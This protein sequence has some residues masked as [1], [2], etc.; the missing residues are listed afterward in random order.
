[1][2]KRSA[3]GRGLE[4]LIPSKPKGI[5]ELIEVPLEKVRPNP[6]QARKVFTEEKIAELAASIAEHGLVQP[7]VVRR[8]DDGYE[9]VSGERRWRAYRSLGRE[10]IPAIVREMGDLEATAALLIENIQREDLSPLEEALAFRRLIE[11]FR[12][13][14]EDL[15]RRVGKSRAAIANTLR[16]LSLPADVQ[17]M[18]AG[19]KL[20]AGH[21]RA[22]AG[23]KDAARQ[24]ALARK[25]VEMDLS[26]RALEAEIARE[27]D[28]GRKAAKRL[29]RPNRVLGEV[30]Q[31]VTLVF[32][33]PV[34]IRGDEERGRVEI[35]YRNRE[36]LQ[37]VLAALGWK[38]EGKP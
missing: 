14:Q 17:A 38:P 16:L 13:T 34:K 10:T 32:G 11:E 20:S 19:G 3:L 12:L 5:E 22:L 18:L 8:A 23:V 4:A 35:P 15:A 30:A 25:T 27:Q 37:R 21:A 6:R 26:V 24:V 36:E 7:V 9:L 1:M 29:R 33:S 28:A 2:V 31:Q